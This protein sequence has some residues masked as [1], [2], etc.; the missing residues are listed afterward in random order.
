VYQDREEDLTVDQVGGS[1]PLTV[2]AD[3]Y[4]RIKAEVSAEHR[5]RRRANP[6]SA[7]KGTARDGAVPARPDARREAA[8]RLGAGV[9]HGTLEKA[10]WLQRVTGDRRRGLRVKL[11]AYRAL[12]AIAAGEPVDYLH[13]QVCGLASAEDLERVA[14]E[15]AEGSGMK[16]SAGRSLEKLRRLE[17]AGAPS[18][19]LARE[20]AAALAAAKRQRRVVDRFEKKFPA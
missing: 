2:L 11:A 20:A 3:R 6:R 8:A 1:V 15:E 5:A 4:A 13:K 9:S 14:R 19:V 18:A 12:E 7:A 10:L 16:T 17:S